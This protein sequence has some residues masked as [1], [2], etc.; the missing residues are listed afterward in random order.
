MTTPV[1][2][3]NGIGPKTAAYL[4]T[5]R[6]TT[7]ERLITYGVDNL[8]KAPGIGLARAQTA[9]DNAKQLLGQT[10][11]KSATVTKA[12]VKKKVK[13]KDKKEKKDKD[14]K[15]NKKNKKDKKDKKKD[16]KKNKKDKKKSK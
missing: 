1:I 3:V 11:T 6:V 8:A 12:T 15:K 2:K 5:K 4:K 9:I 14:K 16:K 13:N 7:A 10:Q